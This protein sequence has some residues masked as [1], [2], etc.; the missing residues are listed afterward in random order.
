MILAVHVKTK[1]QCAIKRELITEEH[2]QL[3]QEAEFLKMLE[4]PSKFLS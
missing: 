4:G 3:P 1:E 2:P